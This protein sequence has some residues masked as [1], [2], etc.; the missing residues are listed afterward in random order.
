M[1]VPHW[2]SSASAFCQKSLNGFY[3]VVSEK[4]EDIYNSS[5]HPFWKWIKHT[6]PSMHQKASYSLV[7]PTITTSEEVCVAVL[8]PILYNIFSARDQRTLFFH[9]FLLR[10]KR[11]PLNGTFFS[12]EVLFTEQPN[13][14]Y[15]VLCKKCITAT[16]CMT[17]EH[18]WFSYSAFHKDNPYIE[19]VN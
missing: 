9:L 14:K 17:N 19:G 10:Y 15:S 7:K 1:V 16:F 13:R 5:N 4:I 12:V 2:F 3:L 8:D 18:Y 11:I 6:H